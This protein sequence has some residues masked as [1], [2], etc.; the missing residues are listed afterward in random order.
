MKMTA[1][2]K[3]NRKQVGVRII[4]PR[5]IE[6]AEHSVLLDEA[7][8]M[9][10]GDWL[11]PPAELRGYKL[12]VDHSSILPQCI[13]AYKSNIAGFGIGVRYKEDFS[14]ETPEMAAEFEKATRVLELLNMDMDTKEVFE[15]VIA[16]RETY[17]IAYVE[18][19]RNALGEVN[20]IEFIRN[21]PSVRKTVP[22]APYTET[23][24]FY[25]SHG[26]QR[27]RRF[28]KYKQQT[29][30]KTVYFKEFGDPRVMDSRDG[31]YLAQGEG[32]AEEFC[33]NEILEF[34]LG[35]KPY[36]EVRWLGQCLGIDGSRKAESLNNRYFEEGRHTPLMF[37]IKGGT[38]SEES[39]D[40]LQGYMNDIKGERGQHAFMVLEAESTENS[41]DFGNAKT[42]EIEIR[43]LASMLQRDEL[44]QEY[45]DN[46]RKRVQ[47]A[48]HLPDL[49]VGYTTD[50]NRATA[51]MA[52]EITEKQVFQ[53]ERKS[54]AW[55]INHKLLSEYAFEYVEAYFLEPNVS[56]LDEL[57]KIL[58]ITERAGGLTPNKAK[59]ITFSLLGGVSENYEGAW[60]EEPLAKNR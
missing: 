8:E 11:E 39:F 28:C 34:A 60:G 12:M 43:D 13:R 3:E 7:A 45:L 42:P 27:R 9:A 58:S 2:K 44:F 5:Q 21:T 24:Y 40:K 1:N 30:S 15:K 50:F 46:N 19:I 35:D 48:F 10:A 36:G 26:E 47:S 53:P 17:G 54:L 29:G 59:E 49:Y 51:G 4:A 31:Q 56:N 57:A 41:T 22:L 6:K 20:G 32:L 37:M 55:V 18:V 52:M 14:E 33:A 25:H 38:L 16:A 23:E